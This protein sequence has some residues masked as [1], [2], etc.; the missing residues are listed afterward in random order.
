[1]TTLIGAC[2]AGK[3]PD[4]AVDIYRR[5]RNPDSYAISQ[6]LMALAE[7]GNLEECLTMLADRKSL[8]GKLKGKRLNQIYEV[9]TKKAIDSGDFEMAR[10][11]IQSLLRR[12]N[13]LSKAIF[14]TIFHCMGLLVTKGLVSRISFSKAYLV[15]RGELKEVD[16]EKFKFLLFLVDSVSSRNLPCEASLYSIILSYGSHLGGLPKKVATLMGAAKTAAGVYSKNK[17]LVEDTML[18]S[19]V[20]ANGWEDLFES[21]DDLRDRLESP[22][23]LPTLRVRIASREVAR[24]LRAEKSVSYRKRREV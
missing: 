13:I 3:K 15:K 14:Q 8:A 24:V 5:I 7:A 10:N 11:V 18:K 6:G 1:M 16:V 23:V 17:K 2:L 19:S 4:L 12:G 22:A 21:Y 20:V 9:M